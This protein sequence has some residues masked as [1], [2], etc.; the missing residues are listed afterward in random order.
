MHGITDMDGS[1]KNETVVF[2]HNNDIRIVREIHYQ[3]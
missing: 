1:S 3:A 2:S